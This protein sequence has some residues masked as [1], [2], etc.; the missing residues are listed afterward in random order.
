MER[1]DFIRLGTLASSTLALNGCAGLVDKINVDETTAK[2][3][4][5][6]AAL[7][8]NSPVYHFAQPNFPAPQKLFKPTESQFSGF[9]A[10]T[11]NLTSFNAIVSK[12]NHVEAT[13][14]KP[15]TE[16][17][18]TVQFQNWWGENN[19]IKVW[20]GT[21]YGYDVNKV[22]VSFGG[23][24]AIPENIGPAVGYSTFYLRGIQ[25]NPRIRYWL[26]Y[27]PFDGAGSYDPYFKPD[28]ETNELSMS[29]P[30]GNSL[31]G[32]INSDSFPFTSTVFP[33]L[34]FFGGTISRQQLWNIM[35]E[36]KKHNSNILLEPNQHSIFAFGFTPELGDIQNNIDTGNLQPGKIRYVAE[37]VFLRTEY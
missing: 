21:K 32:S 3:N 23:M 14:T 11:R 34:K 28:P 25:K 19:S 16:S 15:K 13:V 18:T 35:T 24:I 17:I 10:V 36:F 8:T 2:I 30:L 37:N 22:R 5:N 6:V 20:D 33:N 9:Q 27:S 12:K 31:Y 1:R 7:S 29:C 26:Q 4:S